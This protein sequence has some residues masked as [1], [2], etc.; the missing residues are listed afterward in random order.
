MMW[1]GNFGDFSAIERNL[2]FMNSK[3]IKYQKFVKH[4]LI[5]NTYFCNA[6]MYDQGQESF[7]LPFM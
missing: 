5:E 7:N 2:N 4:I 6:F 3:T 1:M